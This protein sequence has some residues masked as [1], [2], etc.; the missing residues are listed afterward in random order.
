MKDR[1]LNLFRQ[2]NGAGEIRKR[3]IV[4]FSL[5][6]VILCAVVVVLLVIVSFSLGVERGRRLASSRQLPE[7]IYKS[8]AVSPEPVSVAVV[9]EPAAMPEAEPVIIDE[10]EVKKI[11]EKESQKRYIIQ[12]A[13]YLKESAALEE[14]KQIKKQGF[15]V[16]TSKQGKYIVLFVDNFNEIGPAQKAM[17]KLREKYKDCFIRRLP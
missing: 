14:A 8:F 15:S 2:E 13:S 11:E 12:L 16:S 5:D 9:A 3:N 6:T 17:K 10:E 1:Q 7:D 4:S